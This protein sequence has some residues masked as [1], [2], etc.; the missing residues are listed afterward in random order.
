M[1]SK[2][3]V[4][5]FRLREE[6]AQGDKVLELG[7]YTVD[8]P[9]RVTLSKKNPIVEGDGYAQYVASGHLIEIE[10]RI[11]TIDDGAAAAPAPRVPR[12]FELTA[13]A[14]K[15]GKE[16]RIGGYGA[17]E[18]VPVVLNAKNPRVE[19]E[20]YAQYLQLG[21]LQEAIPPA[22]VRRAA[23]ALIEGTAK[24]PAN[25]PTPLER[26]MAR[27]SAAE[28]APA[29][30]FESAPIIAEM[31]NEG[32]PP[33]ADLLKMSRPE[34]EELARRRGVWEEVPATG[35]GEYRTRED[36]LRYFGQDVADP[37]EPP[38]APPL[39]RP[40]QIKQ[41]SKDEL[42]ALAAKLDLLDAIPK[43]GTAGTHTV[44]D[45]SAY[46]VN[47]VQQLEADGELDD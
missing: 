17:G 29:P 24:I 14:R 39:P 13:E 44:K 35:K 34:L 30:V 46:L 9:P 15:G 1:S 3:V 25:L 16:Y 18:P 5:R 11:E 37:E 26:D 27:I 28:P 45:L 12:H 43:T 38:E 31:V 7:T 42:L 47:Y 23:R 4:R 8:G 32:L 2:K 33:A 41:M 22:D 6:H 10:P 21:F 40:T 36:L 19:G 20:G